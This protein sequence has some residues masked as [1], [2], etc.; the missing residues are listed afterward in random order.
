[1]LLAAVS[2]SATG[3]PILAD[4]KLLAQVKLGW[5]SAE[6]FKRAGSFAATLKTRVV[7]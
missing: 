4:G 2:L 1:M 3:L 5:S 6:T 7:S